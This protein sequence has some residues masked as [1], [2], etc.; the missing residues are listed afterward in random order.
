MKQK[1]VFFK[2]SLACLLLFF[3][4]SPFASALEVG[5]LPKLPMVPQLTET[6]T[7]AEYAM[8]FFGFGIYIA[9]T[10]AMIAFVV[11]AIKYMVSGGSQAL[12]KD[13]RDGMIN[14]VIGIIIIMSSA[15]ILNTIN[16]QL[17]TLVAPTSLPNNIGIYYTDGKERRPTSLSEE[18][19]TAISKKYP[20]IIY[21]CD[22]AV[23]NTAPN[24]II[25][26][27][28]YINFG[29]K[30]DYSDVQTRYLRCGD[31]IGVSPSF[32]LALETTG[33]YY[34]THSNCSGFGSQVYTSGTFTLPPPFYKNTRSV[35][36]VNDERN[37]IYYNTVLR[38]KEGSG[39]CQPMLYEAGCYDLGNISPSFIDVFQK[40]RSAISSGDGV[41]FYSK[42]WGWNTGVQGGK[43]VLTK[44]N[45]NP[46]YTI[47]NPEIMIFDYT[48]ANISDNY[49]Q[50]CYK[51]SD[52]PGSVKI[53][54]SYTVILITSGTP[55]EN[56]RECQVFNQNV[57]NLNKTEAVASGKKV[58]SV[59][60][61]Q[62]K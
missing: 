23:K 21:E 62:T 48:G 54:G 45:I 33:V 58:L 2:I 22:P 31:K 57:V 37:G 19:T 53:Q 59:E 3:L 18:D 46:D 25:W 50:V 34:Y 20:N 29:H 24:L 14:S 43:F 4:S 38:Q 61:V 16:P 35:K 39:L 9:G 15:L 17:V 51:F 49:K 56:V 41:I 26:K 28:K 44:E 6:S 10:I 60:V 36:I 47:D 52:C 8:Y 40:N 55:S 1:Q 11:S 7:I 5:S 27:Y 30:D 42:P 12:N 13:A 32:K